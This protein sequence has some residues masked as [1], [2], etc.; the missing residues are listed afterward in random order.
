[1]SG[2]FKSLYPGITGSRWTLNFWMRKNDLSRLAGTVD[3]NN[4][5]VFGYNSDGMFASTN[6]EGFATMGGA[7]GSISKFTNEW[8]YYDEWSN[9]QLQ[10]I[11]LVMI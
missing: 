11:K 10:V 8:G 4:C 5:Y 2:I 3:K 1:M 9:A 6:G 7:T